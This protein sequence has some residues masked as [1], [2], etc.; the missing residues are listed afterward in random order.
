MIIK[1]QLLDLSYVFEAT[2]QRFT[3]VARNDLEFHVPFNHNKGILSIGVQFL[4]ALIEI[5]P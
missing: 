5:K 3:R 4:T 1:L 2:A